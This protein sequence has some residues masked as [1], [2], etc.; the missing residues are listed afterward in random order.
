M[1]VGLGWAALVTG[2]LAAVAAM[3]AAD[4][5]VGV[6][7]VV[8]LVVSVKGAVAVATADWATVA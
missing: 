2:D 7:E 3:E 5:G 6:K 4:C 1:W 8:G